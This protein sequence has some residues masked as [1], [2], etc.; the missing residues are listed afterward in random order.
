MPANNVKN[1]NITASLQAVREALA[2]RIRYY[3]SAFHLTESDILQSEICHD[4]E[5]VR[6]YYLLRMKSFL[7][8]INKP[9][10]K[11]RK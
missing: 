8:T 10:K 7:D 5:K 11:R 4:F 2:N 6:S 3:R 9:P 1:I